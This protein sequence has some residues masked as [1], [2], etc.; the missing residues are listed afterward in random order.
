MYFSSCSTTDKT[1]LLLEAALHA[2]QKAALKKWRL[3][4]YPLGI[5]S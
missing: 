5:T 4:D 3:I 2:K 1:L